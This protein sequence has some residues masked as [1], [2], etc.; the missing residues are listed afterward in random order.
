MSVYP[1]VLEEPDP[2]PELLLYWF[3][4]P[5]AIASDTS[6]MLMDYAPLS[7]RLSILPWEFW[8]RILYWI[9]FVLLLILILWRMSAQR[10]RSRSIR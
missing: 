2:D 6:K 10:Q 5:G 1:G 9:L 4:Q 8:L 3:Q 7:Y